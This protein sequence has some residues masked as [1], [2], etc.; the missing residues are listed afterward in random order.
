MTKA[1]IISG[2]CFTIGNVVWDK[3]DD[4]RIFYVP[5]AVFLL[6]ST[7]FVRKTVKTSDQITIYLLDYLWILAVGNLIK[8]IFYYS[9]TI[10]QVNDYAWG[11]LISL[12]L[13]FMI[14]REKWVIRSKH[15]GKK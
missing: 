12:W 2:I 4:P 3:F 15:Y 13:I 5:L 8:Q 14:I 9:N 6:L 10:K 7:L 11:G 1:F